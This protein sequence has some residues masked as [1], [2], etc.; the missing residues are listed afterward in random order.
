MK[1]AFL[2]IS[3]LLVFAAFTFYG[4]VADAVNG[5]QLG[6][7]GLYEALWGGPIRWTA[8]LLTAAAAVCLIR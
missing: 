7:G 3:P 8:T 5:I 4:L 1:T 6:R 2:V